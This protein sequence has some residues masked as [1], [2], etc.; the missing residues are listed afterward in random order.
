[1]T[2][3]LPPLPPI[4]PDR[5]HAVGEIVRA[6]RWVLEGV[7]PSVRVEGEVT[8]LKVHPASGHCY[9]EL[10]EPGAV[11]QVVMWRGQARFARRVLV[12]GRRIR[13]A[14]RL[15]VWEGGGRFQM[16]AQRAEPAGEGDQA[17]RIEALKLRLQEEGLTAPERKRA[18]PEWPRGIGVVTSLAGAAL[19]DV[20]KVLARRVPVPVVVA[21]CAVQGTEAPA[22]IAAALGRIGGRADVDVVILTRGG[23]SAQDL[24]PFNEESVARAVAACPRPVITAVGHEVDFTV[25]DL[26]GDLRAATPSEAAERAVPTRE[27]AARRLDGAHL[28]LRRGVRAILDARAHRLER[29]A[30][31]LPPAARLVDPVRQRLDAA[32]DRAARSLGRRLQAEFRRLEACR[33]R[34]LSAHPR[35]RLARDRGRL[36]TLRTGLL[37]SGALRVERIRRTIADLRERMR[38]GARAAL[39]VRRERLG[40]TAARLDAL[41][42][43][44]VLGRGYALVRD[45]DGR[46]VTDAATLA[47]AD[48]VEVSLARGAIDCRVERVRR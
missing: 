48:E 39:A 30:A 9:F 8:G 4:D 41:S 21:H 44:A 32:V 47:P 35:W 33:A 5:V 45:R 42:P 36:A 12:E 11:L 14:G 23:G 1:V 20:L 26:V 2:D 40:L 6:A 3:L 34:L 31:A 10:R 15:T 46:L 25:V 22:S 28:R 18:V 43:L 24:M 19:Q 37:R 17:A 7:F 38:G 27:A 13:C 16:V 29:A